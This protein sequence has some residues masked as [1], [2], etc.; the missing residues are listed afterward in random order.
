MKIEIRKAYA[1][2]FGAVLNI[3]ESAALK[4]LAKGV[5]QWD[6][7][8][9]ENE[10]YGQIEQGEFYIAFADE[11]PAG[12]FGIKDFRNNTFTQDSNGLYFYHLAVHPQYS[13]SSLGKE[14]CRWVQ[15]FAKAENR[16]IYFDCWAGNDFLKKFY[17]ENGFEYIG[18]FPEE[19]YFV[20]AFK[21]R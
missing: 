20:S 16:D 14:M 2:D 9:N 11:A 3:L 4:L 5:Q 15:N 6:Y 1:E 8:W 7:P 12:C 13:G 19:D 17:S 21:T 10:L 18:D